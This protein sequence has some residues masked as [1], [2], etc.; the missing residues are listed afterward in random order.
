[1]PPD[2]RAVLVTAAGSL[3]AQAIGRRLALDGASVAFTDA[4]HG[5]ACA[6]AE[7]VR[8]AGGNAAGFAMDHRDWTSTQRAV[9][10]AHNGWSGLDLL[11]NVADNPPAAPFLALAE[12]DLA[13][14]FDAPL[15]GLMHGVRAAAEHMR[16]AGAGCIVNVFPLGGDDN[17]LG[18]AMAGGAEM[19][20][21]AA[22]VELASLGIRVAGV[23]AVS[24][25]DNPAAIADAVAFAASPDASYVTGSTLIVAERHTQQWTAR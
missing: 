12:D 13:D 21:R 2:A 15:A 3:A 8:A 10:A 14:A 25:R 4:D 20:T 9:R 6:A 1:M 16:A 24:V 22:G 23:A 18:G 11:V 17:A 5:L 19:L 7:A